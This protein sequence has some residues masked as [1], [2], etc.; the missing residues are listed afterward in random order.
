MLCLSRI[1]AGRAHH[2]AHHRQDRSLLPTGMSFGEAGSYV[3]MSGPCQGR[4]RPPPIHETRG[5]VN[6]DK[7]PRNA[8]GKVEYEVEF[9]LIAPG[10][11]RRRPARRCSTRSTIAGRKA[12][13]ALSQRGEGRARRPASTIPAT[14]ADGRQR[15]PLPPRLYAGLERLGPGRAE[16]QWR[17]RRSARPIA[18]D[19]GKADRSARSATSS[20]FGTRIPETSPTAP[21]SY[22]TASFDQARGKPHR[23]GEREADPPARSSRASGWRFANSRG[24]SS[25][26]PSAT[27]FKPGLIYDFRY[28]GPEPARSSASV[29]PRRAILSRSCAT[30]RIDDAGSAKPARIPAE[31]LPVKHAIGFGISQERPLSARPYRPRL[32]SG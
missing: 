12:R 8:A 5:I 14:A 20:V 22:E 2:H 31:T 7:A 29:S 3:R 30:R 6:L 19:R 18:S 15:L 16:G 21:L 23:G 32:Q 17:A 11:I 9:Y 27:K 24:D 4:T 26:C 1:P 10:P 28:R 25:Y 13:D